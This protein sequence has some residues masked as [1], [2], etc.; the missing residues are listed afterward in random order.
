MWLHVTDTV[1]NKTDQA[2]EVYI[3]KLFYLT[4]RYPVKLFMLIEIKIMI[5]LDSI[6]W[7]GASRH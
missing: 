4:S 6:D 7:E 2:K 1:M 5:N 3:R